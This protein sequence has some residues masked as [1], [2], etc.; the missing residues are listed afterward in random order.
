MESLK[1]VLKKTLVNGM[2]RHESRPQTAQ[3]KF[4]WSVLVVDNVSVKILQACMQT[5]ELTEENISCIESIEN[6][7]RSHTNTHAIYFL[8]PVSKILRKSARSKLGLLFR[9]CPLQISHF[10][11]NQGVS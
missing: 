3:G 8:S 6:P 1:A 9:K 10:N 4:A 5:W 7:G 2:L 11:A